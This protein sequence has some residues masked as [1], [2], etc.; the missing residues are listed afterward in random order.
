MSEILFRFRPDRDENETV[1]WCRT[2]L[3]AGT[4]HSGTLAD[5]ARAAAGERCVLAADGAALQI[6]VATVPSRQRST[7]LRAVPYILEDQLAEDIERLH[8]SLGDRDGDGL[9]PV[10]VVR[11]DTLS[12]WRG[13]C[14]EAG[15]HLYA[16]VPEPLLIPYWEGEWTVAGDGHRLVIRTERWGGLSI[17]QALFPLLLTMRSKDDPDKEKTVHVLGGFEAEEV[18][19][20]DGRTLKVEDAA[21]EL[22]PLMAV[23]Y[24]RARPINLL[25]GAYSPKAKVGKLVRPWVAALGLVVA[26]VGT[27][28]ASNLVQKHRLEAEADRLNASMEAIYRQT[29][30]ESRNVVNPKLQMERQLATLRQR[31]GSGAGGFLEFLSRSGPVIRSESGLNLT[32]LNFRDGS[33]TLNLS[34]SSLETVDLLR[35][36]LISEAALAVEIQSASS[37]DGKVNSRMLIR[38]GAT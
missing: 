24:Q 7:I 18:G 4:V 16:V 6:A 19:E 15:I 11:R 20:A 13:R 25:Q 38:K 17:D 14:V 36:R 30:P 34:A 31:V 10:I 28:F 29:F 37:R 26:L 2:P 8:F 12:E 27:Q 1:D 22:L 35:E 23:E 9:V 33:L 3:D 5:L 21:A 32:G